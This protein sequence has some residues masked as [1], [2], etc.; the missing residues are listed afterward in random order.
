[1]AIAGAEFPL[2]RYLA[3]PRPVESIQDR[4]I[5]LTHRFILESRF[6]QAASHWDETDAIESLD[7][8]ETALKKR[9]CTKQSSYIYAYWPGYDGLSHHYGP[10]SPEALQHLAMVDAMLDRLRE[11]VAACDTG[12]LV[13]ADHGFVATPL[14]NHIDLS[15]IATLYDSLAT[16]PSGDAR[17]V[18]LFVRPARLKPTRDLLE[19]YQEY[20][21][22]IDG[23]VLLASGTYGPGEQHPS[24]YGR[25]GDLVLL[26][27]SNYALSAPLRG[28]APHRMPGNHGGM[29]E[30]EMRIPLYFCSP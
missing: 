26:A 7:E 11:N 14:A 25:V 15:R 27:K 18:S 19:E 1:M 2:T 3:I 24:L 23:E 12:L 21:S 28:Y 8:L 16:L 5:A 17:A 10:E 6:S 22:V 30:P 20:F 29:T 9:V 13:T 4:R